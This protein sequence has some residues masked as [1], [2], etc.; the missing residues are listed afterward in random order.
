MRVSTATIYD[1]GVFNIQRNQSELLKV[2]EQV[3][4][5]RRVL[6]PADD[7]VSAS[8]ALEVSQSKAITAQFARNTESATAAIG[9]TENSLQRYTTLLQ[10]YRVNVLHCLAFLC[11]VVCP[12]CSCTGYTGHDR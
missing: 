11:F 1:Q 4:T 8:R 6:T 3:S 9:L 5:G 2:Q 7:P 10:G 12:S